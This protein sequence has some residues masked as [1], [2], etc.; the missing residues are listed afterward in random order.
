M[1]GTPFP[2]TH[3]DRNQDPSAH[4]YTWWQQF[5]GQHGWLHLR[6]N[7]LRMAPTYGWKLMAGWIKTSI[8]SAVVLAGLIS[9]YGI[10]TTMIDTVRALP[11]STPTSYDHTGLLATIDQPVR[12]YLA[13]HTQTLPITATTAYSTWQAVGVAAFLLGYLRNTPA[14]LAWTAW[15]VATV[16]MVWSATP[17][18]GRQVAAGITVFTWTTLS[19][20]ALRGISFTRPV[21]VHVDVAAPEVHAE[22]HVPPRLTPY[23]PYDPTKQPPSLN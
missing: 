19:L 18:P 7:E 22:I 8:I 23:K 6:L 4:A 10:G 3:A 1:S 15:G 14:R 21:R 11:W 20:L 16:A 5:S 12:A 17:E 9:M 13:T 2:H